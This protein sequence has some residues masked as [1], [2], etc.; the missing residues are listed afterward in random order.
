MDM[1]FKLFEGETYK[2]VERK[3]NEF[4]MQHKKLNIFYVTQSECEKTFAISIFYK[5]N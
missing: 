3:I 1:Y 4:L 2:D 5:G